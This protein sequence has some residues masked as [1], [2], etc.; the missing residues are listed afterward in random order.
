ME[1]WQFIQSPSGEWYWLCSNVISRQ[2]RESTATFAT[3]M[4]CVVNAMNAGYQK[5]S[6][7][8][9]NPPR[10]H[11]APAGAQAQRH[12]AAP[13]GGQ[14]PKKR[15]PPSAGEGQAP[16]KRSRRNRNKSGKTNK[17]TSA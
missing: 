17:V 15:R 2:T 4:E 16:A 12:P 14:Q 6:A 11:K 8:A 13:S 3:R 9:A 10:Q 1:S 5:M 7:G